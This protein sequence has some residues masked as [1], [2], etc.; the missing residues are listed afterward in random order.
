MKKK[1]LK[2]MGLADARYVDEASPDMN[3]RKSNWKRI[4]G[5]CVACLLVLVLNLVLF[6]PYSTELPSVAQ[7]RESEYYAL[8]QKLNVIN[9]KP[10]KYKNKF[11]LL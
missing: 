3:Y 4:T 7:Y 1:W 11:E 10:P 9:Y 6:I 8:I 2:N 5:V